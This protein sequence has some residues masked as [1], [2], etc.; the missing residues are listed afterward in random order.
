MTRVLC[1][2]GA[3]RS[4]RPYLFRLS[5]RRF[6][7]AGLLAAS[8][9]LLP[10]CRGAVPRALALPS[11][12]TA[13]LR[14]EADF[15]VEGKI[16]YVKGGDVWRWSGGRSQQI[17]RGNAY[18]G[19]AWSPDGTLLAASYMG[20]NH[21][22]VVVLTETGV[23]VRQLTHNFS[24]V[25]V[26]AQAWGRKPAWS[27]D[28]RRVAYISDQG[29]LDA[30]GNKTLDMSLFLVNA[31][32]TDLRKLLVQRPFTGGLDWPTWS[33]DGIRIAYTVFDA[34]PS[35]IQVY[36]LTTGEWRNL[37]NHPEGAYDPAWSPDGRWIA[38]TVRENGR[39]DVHVMRSDGSVSTRITDTGANVAPAWSPDGQL[40]AYLSNVGGY[41]DV[42]VVRLRLADDTAASE[43]RQLT[44][45]ENVEAQSGL[46]WSR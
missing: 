38:Y 23:R 39:H 40:L 36:N 6:L 44:R 27:P 35:Q 30:F 45:G 12:P 5:R 32:G 9:L 3:S 15:A 16:A 25:S 28:G 42:F 17:T 34:A 21:S 20:E 10:G 24:S 2:S 43:P 8:G 14:P 11:T 33:A 19:P 26:K 13:G 22:D 4:S 29:P 37:T 41:F 18:E 46:S 1:S 7:G 31:D